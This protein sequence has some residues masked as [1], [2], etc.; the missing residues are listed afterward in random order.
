M[1]NTVEAEYMISVTVKM[2]PDLLAAVEQ[3]MKVNGEGRAQFIRNAIKASLE[4]KGVRFK[5]DSH[6][7]PDRAGVGGKPT[8]R[9]YPPHQKEALV[10]EESRHTVSAEDAALKVQEILGAGQLGAKA[11]VT[12]LG[13]KPK[14]ASTTGK[15]G[16]PARPA[17]RA[18]SGPQ[19]PP[20]PAP[21]SHGS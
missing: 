21:T 10:V 14:A 3:A 7:A 18:S 12:K 9:N 6:L 2:R 11:A 19:S 8:H 16:G 20:K 17:P 13:L 5:A 4:K 1:L 15:K